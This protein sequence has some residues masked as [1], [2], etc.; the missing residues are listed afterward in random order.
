MKRVMHLCKILLIL[1]LILIC[2]SCGT[3]QIPDAHE[4][5]EIL[6]G[7]YVLFKAVSQDQRYTQALQDWKDARYS[8][9]YTGMKTIRDELAAD[10]GEA[11]L[12]TAAVNSNFGALC[13]DYAKYQEGYEYLNSAYVTFRDQL[14][15]DSEQVLVVRSA[16]CR[17]E[18]LTGDYDTGL[19]D[20]AAILESGTADRDLAALTIAQGITADIQQNRGQY[21]AAL[22]SYTKLL[23]RI[24]EAGLADGLERYD[25]CLG[26]TPEERHERVYLLSAIQINRIGQVYAK[27]HN[28]KEEA[29]N[30]Q[31]LVALFDQ[32]NVSRDNAAFFAD[33]CLNLSQAQGQHGMAGSEI[34]REN[35]RFWFDLAEE[36]LQ[37][38]RPDHPGYVKFNL[39]K[40]Q[41]LY[42]LGSRTQ[43][44][45]DQAEACFQEAIRISEAC[46]GYNHP[47]T[48][49]AYEI[50]AVFAANRFYNPETLNTRAVELAEE[51]IEIR[52]N[53]LAYHNPGTAQMYLLLA[54][55]CKPLDPEQSLEYMDL[56]NTIY[57]KLGL[58]L[59]TREVQECF[60][61]FAQAI[62]NADAD[63]LVKIMAMDYAQCSAN[64]LED[65]LGFTVQP[66]AL[67]QLYRDRYQQAMDAFDA[68]LR[69]IYGDYQITVEIV[70]NHA[71][72]SQEVAEAR[73]T[74]E[75]AIPGAGSVN[76]QDARS[77]RLHYKITGEKLS[78]YYS[79]G[80]L[81]Q[82][83]ILFQID[84]K[85]KLGTPAG[86]PKLDLED[87]MELKPE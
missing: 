51:S 19:K 55:T 14:G 26:T 31:N 29:Q 8:E 66:D 23:T 24:M 72:T 25:T 38:L 42:Y 47:V 67:I 33:V 43:E 15:E 32:G 62:Q 58:T 83:L 68:S 57:N 11:S 82:D 44:E 87:F 53:I 18:F 34:N 20:S 28:L 27:I 75:Q 80:L 30:Y 36:T 13:L 60:V 81:P 65:V 73:R 54:S 59:L 49:Q 69:D 78:E 16:L 39:L 9:A 79:G 22:S 41:D 6:N 48:A 7:D 84:G 40:G 85:W 56:H 37:K 77:M 86:F 1:M 4:K 2:S 50:Y 63:A 12:E 74:M 61:Q 52:K 45:A 3:K 5:S 10:F 46:Y 17:Y 21:A 71:F 35:I 76:L 64:A 70:G